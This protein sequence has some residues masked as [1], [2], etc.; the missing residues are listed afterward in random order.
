MDEKTTFLNAELDEK[1]YMNQ[2]Q[3]FI[4]SGNENK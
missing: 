2:P 1:V 4:M 3:G